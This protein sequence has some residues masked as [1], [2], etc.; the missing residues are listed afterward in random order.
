MIKSHCWTVMKPKNKAIF[1][2][3]TP[4]K[5]YSKNERIDNGWRCWKIMLITISG[6]HWNMTIICISCN[7]FPSSLKTQ[8]TPTSKLIKSKQQS[9]QRKPF[10]FIKCED[11]LNSKMTM[12]TT[13][14]AYECFDIQRNC[15]KIFTNWINTWSI[16]IDTQPQYRFI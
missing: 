8:I 15:L 5:L 9:T 7:S 14:M 2:G 10:K 12:M 11:E 3:P 1:N 4:W 16:Y 6:K 13:A